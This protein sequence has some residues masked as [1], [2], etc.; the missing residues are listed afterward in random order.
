MLPGDPLGQPEALGHEREAPQ[1]GE[2]DAGELDGE[3]RPQTQPRPGMQPGVGQVAAD[4]SERGCRGTLRRTRWTVAQRGQHE[5]GDEHPHPGGSGVGHRP[6]RPREHRRE[7]DGARHLTDLAEDAGQLGEHGHLSRR[8]PRGHDAQQADEGEGVTDADQQP[9]RQSAGGGM[10]LREEKLSGGHH[11]A[12]RDEQ[13]AGAVPVEEDPD[14]H[15]HRGVDRAAAGPRRTRAG[16]HRS[17]NAPTRPR[18]RH[19]ATCG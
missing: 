4:L 15:L 1:Q 9:C 16:R 12:A 5:Q 18:R 6:P 8:E 14:G 17:R 13:G 10:G 7:R 11:D 19:P 3:V 2:E